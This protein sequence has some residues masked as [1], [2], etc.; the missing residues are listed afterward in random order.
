VS[1]GRRWPIVLGLA[2]LAA[3]SGSRCASAGPPT[4]S[5][6]E[7]TATPSFLAPGDCPVTLPRAG[8]TP[9]LQLGIS[10]SDAEDWY[11]NGVLGVILPPGGALLADGQ[12]PDLTTKFPW[13]RVQPGSLHVTGER[14]DGPTGD[15]SAWVGTV[16]EYGARGF[17]PSGLAWP[18]VGCWRVTGT[19]VGHGSLTITMR[20]AAS[21]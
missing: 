17:D 4:T 3:L 20:V 7:P 14:L 13:F 1:H 9:P 21:T 11:G 6:P 15:F 16:P 10:P 5:S 8:G 18:S 2:C 12:P 19:V